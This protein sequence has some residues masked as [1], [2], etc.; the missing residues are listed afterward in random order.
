ME[1]LCKNREKLNIL[2]SGPFTL[3]FSQTDLLLD[4]MINPA[5]TYPRSEEIFN[6]V[7]HGLGLLLS[8]AGL[9]L[10]VVF[11]SLYGTVWHIVSFSIYGASLVLLY[12]ASTVFHSA[13]TQKV[14]NRLNV[15]DHASIYLLIAGTYTPFVLVTLRG[16]WG[17]SLFGVVWGLALA[18]IVL[19][20]FFTGRYNTL[21]TILYVI[22]GWLI[23]IAIKPLS[24][25][26]STEGLFWLMA[27]GVSYTIG[28]VF[29]LLNKIPFNHAIFHVFVLGGSICHF[30]AVF[31]FVLP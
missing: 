27:G 30:V 9:V 26:I 20:L 21:S 22:L 2:P 23:L 6:V 17:W 25:A 19:K 18:G 24:E 14:R 5:R 3:Y 29:F 8:I 16:P 28:A 4:K 15:F 10:L 12:L 1:F 7:S 11:A 13:K 31:W